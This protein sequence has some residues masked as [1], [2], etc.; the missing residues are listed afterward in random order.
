MPIILPVLFIG[1]VLAVRIGYE[2][3]GYHAWEYRAEKIADLAIAMD[4]PSQCGK[5]RVFFAFPRTTFEEVQYCTYTVA[6]LTKNPSVCELL[7]PSSYGFSCIG[8]ANDTPR[9]CTIGFGRIVEW[10]SYLD[11]THQQATLPECISNTI[12][13][14]LGK[15]CCIISKAA[16]LQGF[17]D[18]SSFERDPPMH[19]LCLSE[20][21]L[22][23][24]EPDVCTPINEEKM[25]VA[26]V[27]RAKYKSALPDYPPAISVEAAAQ[28]VD[29]IEQLQ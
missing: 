28:P 6:K 4:D 24:G 9:Q 14:E 7:M 23:L 3:L 1:L 21:A 15:Q 5:I 18:C 12:Q 2:I 17:D 27:L 13:S 16:N 20:L 11:D 19:N 29:S 8:A 10:G 25:E 26:C 22:K